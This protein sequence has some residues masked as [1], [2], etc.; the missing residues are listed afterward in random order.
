MR[1]HEVM[2]DWAR[3]G[4]TDY[5]LDN[6][7]PE[8]RALF[9]EH[10]AACELCRAEVEALGGLTEVLSE[11]APEGPARPQLWN[12]IQEKLG[13]QEPADQ[14][15]AAEGSTPEGLTIG[16]QASGSAP[17][18]GADVQARPTPPEFCFDT[19]E[20]WTPAPIPGI[21]TRVLKVD[22]HEDRVTFEAL[23]EPGAV[24]PAHPHAGDEECYVISGDLWVGDVHMKAGDYQ[25]L[26]AGSTHAVQS[27][28][29]G[30]RIL[31]IG[32]R[33]NSPLAW[34]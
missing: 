4:V 28:D 20:S 27:S 1:A 26:A 34:A 17:A 23:I 24:Y 14:A 31:L 3:V 5:V 25:C 30:A 9:E 8:A 19:P 6:L 2:D 33:A 29:N 21:Q 16:E 15:P 7:D 18:P 11:P 32:A 10:L 13:E 12:R 22:E